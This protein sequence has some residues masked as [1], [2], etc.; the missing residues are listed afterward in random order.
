M[1]VPTTA[2]ASLLFLMTCSSS[3]SQLSISAGGGTGLSSLPQREGNFH[4]SVGSSIRI[5]TTMELGV[6]VGY[7]WFHSAFAFEE[8]GID[9]TYRT[10]AVPIT[11]NWR[12]FLA[13]TGLRPYAHAELGLTG[14]EWNYAVYSLFA[15]DYAEYA[16]MEHHKGRST[17]WFPSAAL[18]VGALIPLDESISLDLGLRLGIV[19]GGSAS[20]W[21]IVSGR[22]PQGFPFVSKNADQWS[23]LR[24][25]AA[26]RFEL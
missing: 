26:L 24:F 11:L 23:Y 2:V 12:L 15:T 8:Q 21:V 1:K 19:G 25:L 4:F 10:V 20:Q 9:P 3:F 6:S 18:G 7:Q 13:E 14:M 22:P 16:P 5:A 17:D